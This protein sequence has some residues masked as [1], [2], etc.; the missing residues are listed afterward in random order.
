MLAASVISEVF[1]AHAIYGAFLAGVI[2]SQKRKRRDF[3]LMKTYPLVIGILAPVYFTSIGLKA[4]F[5]TNFDLSII[6]LVFIVACA[7]KIIGAGLGANS[8]AYLEKR[9][10]RSVLG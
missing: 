7:G 5:A 3:I 9:H 10:W 6:L 8:A 4:N 1:G 2:L